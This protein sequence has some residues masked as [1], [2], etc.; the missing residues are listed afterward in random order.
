MAPVKYNEARESILNLRNQIHQ[1]SR[2]REQCRKK[3]MN[4]QRMFVLYDALLKRRKIL[5]K[6]YLLTM[7]LLLSVAK[8]NT[9][10]Q[11][12]PRS[13]RRH[14]RNTGWWETV[15]TTYSDK[16]FKQTIRVSRETFLFILDH[17][18]HDLQKY[19]LAEEPI[20]PETRLGICL[21]R[22]GRG[23]YLFTISEMT[24]LGT[25]TVCNIV[26]EVSRAIIENLWEESVGRHW[27]KTEAEFL[28]K[29]IEMESM[30]QFPFCFGG[31][32]GCHIP[33]RC[34]SGGREANKE[35]HNFKNFYSIVLMG[36]VDAKYRFIWASCGFPGNSHDSIIF[37]ATDLFQSITEG[38]TIPNI[39]K[40]E[41]GVMI[42]PLI[43]GDSAFPFRKWLMKPFTNAVLSR[44]ERYFNYRLS[45]AR[46]VTEG[47]Y[48]RLK[49]RWRVLLRKCESQK[50]TVKVMT[51][52][53]LALHNICIDRGDTTPKSW[54]LN[55]DDNGAQRRPH[56]QVREM[57]KM[58]ACPPLRGSVNR[59]ASKVR[60]VLKE[61]FWS[62]KQGHGVY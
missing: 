58:R 61:K 7:L 3:R 31:V 10:L 33:I 37:Q 14:I 55:Y 34:P 59:Q 54:D 27:P 23:D 32:D 36:M 12:K 30:W 13:C 60:K 22:L 1:V 2:Q 48:G 9:M 21:Y 28:E 40:N 4:F 50:E 51:L 8:E 56:A 15:W 43:L 44:E 52:A 62:E 16:R 6:A 38:D 57:L 49:G 17:I 41:N 53:C 35:Y 18:K 26:I 5:L 24:G 39:A 45:R 47:A 29:M 11:R 42:S 20:S 46:M 25:P 19:D